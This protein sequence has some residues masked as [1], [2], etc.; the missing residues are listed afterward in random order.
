MPFSFASTHR[1]IIFNRGQKNS[2]KK[3]YLPHMK[4]VVVKG[5]ARD[6]RKLIALGRSIRPVGAIGKTCVL[7]KARPN[8]ACR[9]TLAVIDH[10][11]S[12]VHTS[13]QQ[14][15]LPSWMPL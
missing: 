2:I 1:H 3:A 5:T 15:I 14:D 13:G 11:E 12:I 6:K 9:P 7:H 8:R 4:E 10:M